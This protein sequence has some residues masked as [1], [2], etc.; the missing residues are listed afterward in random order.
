MLKMQEIKIKCGF[1]NKHI[2]KAV[3]SLKTDLQSIT[4][5][6]YIREVLGFAMEGR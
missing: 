3:L 1:K 4:V 2:F 6:K 5:T